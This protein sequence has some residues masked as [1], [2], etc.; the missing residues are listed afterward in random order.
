MNLSNFQELTIQQQSDLI[1]QQGLYIGKRKEQDKTFVLYQL[2]SFY[3]EFSYFIYRVYISQ[4]SITV[5]TD[6]LDLYYHSQQEE[7]YVEFCMN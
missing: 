5:S 7:N 1:Y 3:V 6:I 2:H 4:V